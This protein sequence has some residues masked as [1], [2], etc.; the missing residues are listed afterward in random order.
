MARHKSV[1]GIQYRICF[2]SVAYV[3]VRGAKTTGPIAK[4][5]CFGERPYLTTKIITL[6]EFLNFVHQVSRL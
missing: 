1:R 6:S 2:S 5:V 4:K 3:W